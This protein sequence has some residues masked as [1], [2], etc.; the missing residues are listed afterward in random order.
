MKSLGHISGLSGLYFYTKV[1]P[2][3][4]LRPLINTTPDIYLCCK[5]HFYLSKGSDCI[6]SHIIAVQNC[7][8]LSLGSVPDVEDRVRTETRLKLVLYS[9]I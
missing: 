7:V 1:K 9:A 4:W 3:T 5:G 8:N 6:A 2:K